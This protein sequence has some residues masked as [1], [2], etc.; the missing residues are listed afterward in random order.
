MIYDES[1]IIWQLSLIIHSRY[2]DFIINSHD[3]SLDINIEN[4]T[5]RINE[6]SLL[7]NLSEIFLLDG[8]SRTYNIGDKK[9]IQLIRFIKY[10]RVCIIELELITKYKIHMQIRQEEYEYPTYWKY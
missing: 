9:R 4:S 2:N 10:N 6:H 7:L 1:D 8:W 5:F 3:E